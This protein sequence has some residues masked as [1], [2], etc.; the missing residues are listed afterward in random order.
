MKIGTPFLHE[1]VSRAL[2]TDMFG[3]EGDRLIALA[4]LDIYSHEKSAISRHVSSGDSSC[5]KCPAFG[6]TA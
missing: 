6:T 3:P 1:Y 5:V 2:G 4:L